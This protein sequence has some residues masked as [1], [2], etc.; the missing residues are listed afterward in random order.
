MNPA[1]QKLKPVSPRNLIIVDLA[2]A[3]KAVIPTPHLESK[4]QLPRGPQ[5]FSM[6]SK[7]VSAGS[8]DAATGE[9]A[10][11]RDDN[12]AAAAAAKSKA[13]SRNAEWEA[14]QRLLEEERQRREEARRTAAALDGT[15]KSLYEVLQANKGE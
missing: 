13:A 1:V 5:G 15:E 14:A 10:A 12:A 4:L 7:F 9:A 6:P 2:A 8:I 11:A 3:P